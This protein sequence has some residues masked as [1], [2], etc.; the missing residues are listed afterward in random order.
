[1]SSMISRLLQ[2]EQGATAIE[3]GLLCALIAIAIMGSLT[4]VADSTLTMWMKVSKNTLDA[5]TSKVP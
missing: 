5:T 3:Y 1:M 4:S 2:D